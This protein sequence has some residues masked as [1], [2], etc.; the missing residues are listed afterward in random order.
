MTVMLIFD[1]VLYFCEYFF[2]KQKI[3]EKHEKWLPKKFSSTN[4]IFISQRALSIKFL[5]FVHDMTW[6]LKNLLQKSLQCF[7]MKLIQ[8][9]VIKLFRQHFSLKAFFKL[10]DSI[11]KFSKLQKVNAK[12]PTSHQV[13]NYIGSF[14]FQLKLYSINFFRIYPYIP[15]K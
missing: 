15:C 8:K 3:F 2:I 9:A 6:M 7:Y 13:T 14:T 5:H 1:E 4:I 10:L 11:K 12:W